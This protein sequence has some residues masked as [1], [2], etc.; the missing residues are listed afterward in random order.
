MLGRPDRPSVGASLFVGALQGGARALGAEAGIAPGRSADIVS[1]DARDPGL[2]G[3]KGDPLLDSWIFAGRTP[4]DCVW[5]RGDKV[6]EAGRHV[7]G[8]AIRRRYATTL[9]RLLAA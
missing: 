4:I 9:A 2:V 7:R 3:R 6:V 1:L 8:D 5:R